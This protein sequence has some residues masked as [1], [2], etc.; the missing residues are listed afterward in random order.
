MCEVN[1]D[2][3]HP[4]DQWELLDCIGHGP[5]VSG[6]KWPSDY[7]WQCVLGGFSPDIPFQNFTTKVED[8]PCTLN[9]IALQRECDV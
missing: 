3:L 2:G 8:R 5:S 6:V 7:D 9:N 1:L 4:F